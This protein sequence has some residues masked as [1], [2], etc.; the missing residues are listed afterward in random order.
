MK[1]SKRIR[2]RY[3]P[4]PTGFQHIGGIRTAIYNYLIAKSS[5]GDFLLRIEDTDT[6]RFV[7]GTEQYIIDTLKWLDI[8]YDEGP[9]IGGPYEPYRQSER[10]DLYK[11]YAL[12]LIKSGDAYYAFD[13][14]E[15]LSLKRAEAESNETGFLY[16]YVT[17]DSFKNSLSLNKE[18]TQ[19]LLVKGMP[20]TI[21]L[22]LPPNEI[23]SF[24]DEIRGDISVHTSTLEDKILIKSDGCATYH[25]ASVV[26]DALMEI[27]DVVRGE[28]WLPSAPIHHYLYEI[29][30]WKDSKPRFSHLPLVLN[31]DGE[32]KLSKRKLKDANIPIFPISWENESGKMVKGMREEGFLPNAVLNTLVLLGW[33]ESN[34]KEIYQ[35]DELIER[36]N[37]KNFLKSAAKFDY[38]KAKWINSKHIQ[39]SDNGDIKNQF[40]KIYNLDKESYYEHKLINT[41]NKIKDRISTL[42]ELFDFD[43]LFRRNYPCIK[44]NLNISEK[45]VIAE[46][47]NS[48]STLDDWD[49]VIIFSILKKLQNNSGLKAQEYFQLIRKVLTGNEE[50]IELVDIIIIIEKEEFLKRLDQAIS[51]KTGK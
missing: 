1:N 11:K 30:G 42:K 26:D 49:N 39:L 15:N 13:T 36:F 14:E 31:P 24:Y 18:S 23:I 9:N 50:G 47:L 8:N 38:K 29:F 51:F 34:D 45:T 19:K 43:Y 41:I 17:R 4:S 22:K 46:L 5:G 7:Y 6:K 2:T 10:K 35:R 32:G 3:A 40:I 20:Y 44:L 37:V 33:H 16:N 27:T 48:I 21:R 12:Q 25:L 28:E